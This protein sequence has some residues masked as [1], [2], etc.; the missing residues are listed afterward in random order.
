MSGCAARTRGCGFGRR[1]A[2]EAR[3]GH[4][5]VTASKFEKR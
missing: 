1:E 2:I 4:Q 3:A 5:Y